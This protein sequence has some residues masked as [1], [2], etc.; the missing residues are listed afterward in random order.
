VP[1]K[2]IEERHREAVGP[3]VSRYSFWVAN[4]RQVK[5]RIAPG[6][7]MMRDETR[8]LPAQPAEVEA[9]RLSAEGGPWL[10]RRYPSA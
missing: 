4:G 10:R 7:A 9:G 2:Q 3:E 1:R 8:Y 6:P 5:R